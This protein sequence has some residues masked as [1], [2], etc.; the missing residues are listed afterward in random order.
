M[1]TCCQNTCTLTLAQDLNTCQKGI[2]SLSL[3][4]AVSSLALGILIVLNINGIHP[5]HINVISGMGHIGFYTLIGLTTTSLVLSSAVWISL[6]MKR[7]SIKESQ[8]Q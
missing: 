5:A 4:L 3:I 7:S 1:I 2:L 6:L 8:T